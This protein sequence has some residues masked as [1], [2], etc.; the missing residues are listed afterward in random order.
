M[1]IHN[2]QYW[3]Q[4]FSKNC[5]NHYILENK[6]FFQSS[7]R[8]YV[9]QFLD[10]KNFLNTDILEVHNRPNYISQIKESYNNKLFLLRD[11]V[12]DIKKIN[13]FGLNKTGIK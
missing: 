3:N 10:N 7:N 6:N 12:I 1:E 5:L 8:Y 2:Q 4:S 13:L 9:K 11:P